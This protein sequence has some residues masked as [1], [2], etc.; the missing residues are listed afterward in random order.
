MQKGSM[1][2][3]DRL[4]FDISHDKP[5]TIK[6]VISIED[7]INSTIRANGKVIT[8]I[9]GIKEAEKIGA[10]ALFGEKYDQKVRVVSM[11]DRKNNSNGSNNYSIELCGGTH[12][13]S[14]GEIGLVKIISDTALGSGVRR[15]EAV[16]GEAAIK[17]VQLSN[18]ILNTVSVSL[19]VSKE[20]IIDRIDNLMQ[21]RKNFEK[22]I[23][24]LRKKVNTGGISKKEGEF[25]EISGI[26]VF[27]KILDSTPVK[28]LKGLTDE[29]KK[30]IIEGIVIVI[31]IENKKASIVVG[32]TENL[33]N[34][35]DAQVLVKIGVKCLGGQ[36]GGGRKDMAQGGGPKYANVE[37][38]IKE[39]TQAIENIR[40]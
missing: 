39:I 5:L 27:S 18:E 12:V 14:L 2:A 40:N 15:V 10:L 31:G 30:K 19:K 9:M 25:F 36:G 1:V 8:K 32:V 37:D 24:E 33:L 11:E 17:Y 7:D 20:K 4:R 22:K 28:E 16:A 3:S 26:K 6:E 13:S 34:Q 21:E 29:F 35:F 23:Q 38:A